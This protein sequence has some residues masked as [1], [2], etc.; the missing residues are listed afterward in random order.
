[1]IMPLFREA[2]LMALIRLLMIGAR[3]EVAPDLPVAG[4]IVR[5]MAV[6]AAAKYI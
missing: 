3:P 6:L 4:G 2:A 1:M 5:R